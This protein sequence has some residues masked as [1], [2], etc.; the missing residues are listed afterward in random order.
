MIY[1][2]MGVSGCG[3]STIG[4]RLGKELSLP[5]YDADDFHPIENITKMASGKPLNDADRAPWLQLLAEKI[6]EWE[7]KGG[8]VIACSALKQ[9]Y[10]DTLTSTTEDTVKFVFLEG[11]KAV[12][13]ARLTSR[14][15]HFMPNTLL[16]SQLSTLEVPHEAI[17]VSIENSI[18]QIISLILKDISK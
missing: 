6:V 3:K 10:R 17:K 7:A 18:E 5:F 16:D 14:E 11:S 1:I 8:A 12:L 13:H 2:V 15:S 9:A 4:E